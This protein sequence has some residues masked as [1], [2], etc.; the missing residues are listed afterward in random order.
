MRFFFLLIFGFISFNSE[1]ENKH[2]IVFHLQHLN[3]DIP[4]AQMIHVS[5]SNDSLRV[6]R[7]KFY[8]SNI[9]Y[10]VNDS[11]SIK[12]NKG[13]QLLTWQKTDVQNAKIELLDSLQYTSIR[14]RIGIDSIYSVSGALDGD[15]DPSNGMYWTWQ[16]GYINV[17]LEGFYSA[18]QGLHAFEFH[19]GAYRFPYAGSQ[20]LVFPFNGTGDLHLCIDLGQFF[21]TQTVIK[22]PKIMSPGQNALEISN[23]FS[24]SIYLM[25]P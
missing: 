21:K 25:N 16:S 23:A 7:L 1:A 3:L 19:L 9:E 12:S 2:H 4:L 6:D 14:F 8:V 5:N 13:P 11:V 17:K 18:L 10:L 15:L 22:N 24:H 20:T